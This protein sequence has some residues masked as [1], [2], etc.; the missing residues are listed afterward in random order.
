MVVGHALEAAGGLHFAHAGENA[1]GIL[2]LGEG[3]EPRVAVLLVGGLD[4]YG[5]G[6]ARGD[7]HALVLPE[8]GAGALPELLP[9]GASHEA[10]LRAEL[11]KARDW[12][13]AEAAEHGPHEV[14]GLI[15]YHH[16]HAGGIRLASDE[17]VAFGRDLERLARGVV[18]ELVAAARRAEEVHCHAAVEVV[19][20]LYLAKAPRGAQ[21]EPVGMEGH[22]A[23]KAGKRLAE[24]TRAEAHAVDKGHQQPVLGGLAQSVVHHLRRRRL[25]SLLDKLPAGRHERIGALKVARGFII[26]LQH[27]IHPIS[28]LGGRRFGKQLR[29]LLRRIRRLVN[30]LQQPSFQLFDRLLH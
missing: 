21:N 14:A 11:L 29:Q 3:G 18:G 5:I 15:L 12:H 30:Q 17:N 4:V 10:V 9:F 26:R 23:S 28:A 6:A 16:L 25:K 7:L 20:A 8:I 24:G 19:D 27:K 2:H 13:V 22:E 1:L